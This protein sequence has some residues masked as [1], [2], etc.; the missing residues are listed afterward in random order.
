MRQAPRMFV[1]QGIFQSTLM[2][3]PQDEYWP[4]AG[5]TTGTPRVGV[6]QQT[7]SLRARAHAVR[8]TTPQAAWLAVRQRLLASLQLANVTRQQGRLDTPTGEWNAF[9]VAYTSALY[10]FDRESYPPS[11]APRPGVTP[12][13]AGAPGVTPPGTRPGTRPPGTTPGTGKPGAG[14]PSSGDTPWDQPEGEQPPGEQRPGITAHPAFWPMTLGGGAVLLA[15]LW[16][17]ITGKK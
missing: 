8:G 10:T 1:T 3:L 9:N 4:L 13:G 7:A 5:G 17:T 2:G 15:L 11:Q 14:Q 16:P 6:A 12:P